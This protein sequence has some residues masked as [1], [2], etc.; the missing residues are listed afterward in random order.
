M[1]NTQL[2]SLIQELIELKKEGIYW[3]FKQEHHKNSIDFIHDIICLA[4]AKHSGNRYLIFGVDDNCNIIGLSALKKQADIIDT[5]RN[6]KFADDTFPDINL[7]SIT[8]ENKI[9]DILIIKD[10]NDKPY[11]LS[12]EKKENK[13]TINAGTIYSRTMDTNTPKNRVA[14]SKDIEQMWKERFGLTQTPV[15]RFKIYLN[16]FEGWEHRGEQSFYN[17]YPEFTIKP[18][19]DNYCEGCEKREWA[20]DEI[21]YHYD[22]GN[23]TS[24]FGFY[25]HTTLIKQ[26]CCVQFDGGKK[27][28]VN[29]DWEAIGKGRIYFYFED[30]FEY[31]YQTF[32]IRERKQDFSRSIR[33]K[34]H[35]TF[36][37]PI[38][39]DKLELNKFLKN[40]K[41]K[42]EINDESVSPETNKDMQNEL[43]YSYV[44]YY[45]EWSS[46]A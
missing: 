35:S 34:E 19:E 9:L 23:G 44:E 1:D 16:D 45:L 28:I 2:K 26:V 17:Q 13:K 3:D 36:D 7:E 42:F 14:S 12:H 43:F 31:V 46:N 40:A 18:L 32:L 25:Y 27:Y 41:I 33:S 10:T 11:Y 5:L 8:I 6:A 15:D 29:P 39:F 37:I 4:N 24:V 38:F 21:G 30:S 20:R 22:S